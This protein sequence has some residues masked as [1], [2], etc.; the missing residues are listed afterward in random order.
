MA[1]DPL[2]DNFEIF[3]TQAGQTDT[4]VATI[5]SDMKGMANGQSDS[6]VGVGD[7]PT[8]Q[9]NLSHKLTFTADSTL[10][11]P[12]P[13]KAQ[14]DGG[15]VLDKVGAE[16]S[17]MKLDWH[18]SQTEAVTIDWSSIVKANQTEVKH[19]HVTGDQEVTFET[20]ESV[21][22]DETQSTE[23]ALPSISLKNEGEDVQEAS[24]VATEGKD[25]M[26]GSTET[27]A[28]KNT[29]PQITNPEVVPPAQGDYPFAVFPADKP[30]RIMQSNANEISALAKGFE[31]EHKRDAVQ[32]IS[33]FGQINLPSMDGEDPLID[34]A[35]AQAETEAGSSASDS[36]M[37]V[38]S[39]TESA[40]ESQLSTDVAPTV[41]AAINEV[42]GKQAATA[43]DKKDDITADTI[44]AETLM[45]PQLSTQTT[46]AGM[47]ETL[48]GVSP[49]STTNE[50]IAALQTETLVDTTNQPIGSNDRQLGEDS[51]L[52][53][54]AIDDLLAKQ[55]MTPSPEIV[56]MIKQ[57]GV[58]ALDKKAK[59]LPILNGNILEKKEGLSS[60]DVKSQTVADASPQV[61][62]EQHVAELS[63]LYALKE[64]GTS[65]AIPGHQAE[66]VSYGYIGQFLTE[67]SLNAAIKDQLAVTEATKCLAANKANLKLFAE[68]LQVEMEAMGIH[69]VARFDSDSQGQPINEWQDSPPPTM[70]M[71]VEGNRMQ[72]I[73]SPP[74]LESATFIGLDKQTTAR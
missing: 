72:V 17:A 1:H 54:Q 34:R 29:A 36:D 59:G 19:A 68:A 65:G 7:D 4:R 58:E 21:A 22:I 20:A 56:A 48:T 25:Q 71:T 43:M 60:V 37:E 73:I 3:E 30:K 51:L 14:L 9:K 42:K 44:E 5:D 15:H 41:Q 70:V 64:A 26:N 57:I 55:Q 35:V 23:V 50:A 38:P 32:A 49:T 28:L 18:R 12:D 53:E 31:E 69:A 61:Q 45:T 52:S 46:L 13:D 10:E 62:L 11:Y 24:I 2:D 27:A 39:E 40:V 67:A 47:A 6:E 74:Q 33:P 63:R 16:P 8:S 66:N